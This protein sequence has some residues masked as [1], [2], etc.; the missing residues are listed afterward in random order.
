M[1]RD[2]IKELSALAGYLDTH[3]PAMGGA[4]LRKAIERLTTYEEVGAPEEI[5]RVIDEYGRG[6]TLRTTCA[7]RLDII[8]EIPTEELQECVKR[9]KSVYEPQPN[10]PLTL[11]ELQGMIGEP[12]WVVP[13]EKEP[14]WKSCWVICMEDYILVHSTTNESRV[15]FLRGN[16][17]YNKTW[18]AYRHKP[19]E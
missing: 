13:L 1:T 16:E 19:S 2:E 3:I 15:Y 18:L 11:A 14:D 10:N 7:K 12:L 8:K 17:D 5:N 6:M 9:W 4:T